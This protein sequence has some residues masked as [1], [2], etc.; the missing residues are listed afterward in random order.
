VTLPPLIAA[1]FENHR[2]E[3]KTPIEEWFDKHPGVPFEGWIHAVSAVQSQQSDWAYRNGP[4]K[5][6]EK[7]DG[8]DGWWL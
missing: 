5:M 7:Y 6:P 8:K 3:V 1:H 4:L 2:S